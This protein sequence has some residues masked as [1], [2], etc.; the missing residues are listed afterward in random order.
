M[1][2]DPR[3]NFYPDNYMGGTIGFTLEQHGAYLQL[4]I[5]N[6]KLGKFTESQ[7]LDH[8]NS[9]TRGNTAVS[10]EL[11]RFLIHKFEREG[12][13]FFSG[14]LLKEMEKSKRHSEKQ[15]ERVKT[16]WNKG[17]EEKET[18]SGTDNGNTAVLP[19]NRSGIGNGNG[20]EEKGVQGETKPL[21]EEWFSQILDS[22]TM[23]E[24]NYT[25][26]SKDVAEEIRL[27]KAKAR[28]APSQYQHRDKAGIMLAI[29][30][31]LRN[32]KDKKSNGT[33]RATSSVIATGKD[34]GT[35]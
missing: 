15:S 23:D 8:L 19:V 14:R 12:Q 13:F 6:S 11:W 1:A 32:A 4:L 34:F 30:S 17:K 31:Q 2:K 33:H 22:K 27:F 7:A 18:Q 24:L 16:R 25:Y 5:L 9:L 26:R 35:L 21:S 29:H 20:I 3:F 10:T 28:G